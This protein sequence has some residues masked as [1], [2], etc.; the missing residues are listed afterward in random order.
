VAA[1]APL[2]YSAVRTYLEC[3]QRYK[4]L[5]IDEIPEA[6]RGYFSFGRSIHSVLEDLLRPLVVP[7]ARVTPEGATQRTLLDWAE[8]GA[9]PPVPGHLMSDAELL[10][11]YDAHWL[12]DGYLSRDEEHRYKALGRAMLLGYRDDL[13]RAPPTPL[14]V[15]EHL[16]A[17]WNGIRIHGYIDRIDRRPTGGLEILDYKTSKELSREDARDSDQLSLYQVLVEKNYP[18]PVDQLTLVHLRSRTP[19][20]VPRRDEDVLTD[21][22]DRVGRTSEGIRSQSFEPTPG[23]VCARCEFRSLCPEFKEVPAADRERLVELVD[24]FHALRADEARVESELRSTAEA[25]HQEAERLG[26]HRIPG[27]A[28]V[29]VR[30]RE[31]LWKFREASVAP[32][33][34]EHGLAGRA[35]P[36]DAEAIRRLTQDRSIQPAVRRRLIEVGGRQVRWYWTTDD[37]S[38]RS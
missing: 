34:H 18:E 36:D 38:A 35:R 27:S 22:E 21:L 8:A 6:P 7:S 37:A 11:A 15:E 12:S 26:V 30:K 16:E 23:R 28:A 4:F 32:I 13:A 2:S 14:A 1:A 3:P 17:T 24:R 10:A 20:S 19:H 31:E 25:L 5:Y 29:L 9:P 33:L